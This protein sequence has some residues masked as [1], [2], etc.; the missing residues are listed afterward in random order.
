MENMKKTYISPETI[1][2]LVSTQSI[3]GTSQNPEGFN[4]NLDD[5]NTITPGEMLSRRRT[6]VWE[7]EEEEEY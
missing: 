2:V 5:E 3:M 6:S 4:S 7:E 1:L